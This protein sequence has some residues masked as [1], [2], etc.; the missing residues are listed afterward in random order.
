[1][2]QPSE[3]SPL[4]TGDALDDEVD[5][6]SRSPTKKESGPP[7]TI[8]MAKPAAQEVPVEGMEKLAVSGNPP[9]NGQSSPPKGQGH[10]SQST[11]P[12][13]SKAESGTRSV[14]EPAINTVSLA[15][16]AKFKPVLEAANVDMGSLNDR[17][18][19][20]ALTHCRTF[21]TRQT[22]SV[23]S[24]GPA[25]PKKS[26]PCAGK[27]SWATFPV[28]RTGARQP[29]SANGKSTRTWSISLLSGVN[30]A[31]TRRCCGRFRSM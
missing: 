31:W 8:S 16:H 30:I 17:A 13:K 19:W 10:D 9:A 14:A 7:S 15:R 5:L 21:C 27:S 2:D 18:S 28:T 20:Y 26:G 23:K 24:P 22:R 11:S 29:Y 25:F 4:E 6:G 1:M 3:P 12:T